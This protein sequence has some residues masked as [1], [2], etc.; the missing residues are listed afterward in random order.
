M[1]IREAKEEIVRTVRAYTAKDDRGNYR[2]PSVRQR[3]VLLIGPPGIG[4]TAIME[5]AAEEIRVGLLA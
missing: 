4:K 5:Q 3:P 2:I 1:N